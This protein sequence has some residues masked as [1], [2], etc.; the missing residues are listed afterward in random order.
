MLLLCLDLDG[1]LWDHEDVSSLKLPFKRVN[2]N[3]FV[4]SNGVTVNLFPEVKW[5]LREVRKLPVIVSTLS[6]NKFENAY[7]ALKVLDLLIYFDYVVAEFHPRKDV[8]LL[9]LLDRIKREKG[10]DIKVRNIIY[11]DDNVFH[12]EE[13]WE[14]VGP[15][16]F[17][18]KGGNLQNFFELLE[19]IKWKLI[20][21]D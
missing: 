3:S 20:E 13:I 1:T 8:M 2:E 4:D 11:V 9:K 14:N 17:F 21:E 16:K 18:H 6:W 7:E 19:Y 10:V 15:V 5:F 12:I